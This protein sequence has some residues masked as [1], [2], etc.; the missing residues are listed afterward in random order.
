MQKVKTLARKLRAVDENLKG[1][2]DYGLLVFDKRKQEFFMY[3]YKNNPAEITNINNYKYLIRKGDPK[4]GLIVVGEI[5]NGKKPL[6]GRLMYLTFTYKN[7]YYL[8]FYHL[9]YY[10]KCKEYNLRN[11]KL[12]QKIEVLSNEEKKEYLLKEKE[13]YKEFT[14]NMKIINIINVVEYKKYL[15]M[16]SFEKVLNN[17]QKICEYNP[18]EGKQLNKIIAQKE[19]KL[20]KIIEEINSYKNNISEKYNV[21]NDFIIDR[22]LE[23]LEK[24]EKL[25]EYNNKKEKTYEKGIEH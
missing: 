4:W 25:L 18:P 24:K 10:K 6:N 15:Q 7:Y 2:F 23:L 12:K 9:D 1:N 17:M 21:Y 5:G 3:A 19:E 20:K 8:K 16:K 11:E 22:K 14:E 13:L